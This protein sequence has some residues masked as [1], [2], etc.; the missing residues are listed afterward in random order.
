MN[1]TILVVDDSPSV[2]Q[3]LATH[4]EMN[5]YQVLEVE[6]GLSALELLN[7]H[8]PAVIILDWMM[9]G[10]EGPEVAVR[11][12][13]SQNNQA[14][15]IIMLT[16]R[17]SSKDQ[18]QGLRTGVDLYVTKPF[19]PEVLMVQVEKGVKEF[20]KRC[21]ALELARISQTDALTGLFN[22]RFFDEAIQ[23]EMERAD[24]YN[25][26]LSFIMVDLDHFKQVNDTYGHPVGD[27]VL[28]ELAQ[29][30]RQSVRKSDMVFRYGGEEF[31]I[32]LPEATLEGVTSLG[33]KVRQ[34]IENHQFA[35]VGH[36]TASL[37][38]TVLASGDTVETLIQRADAALYSAK[39]NGRN[40]VVCQ[41][42]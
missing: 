6:D 33:E 3:L 25:R 8:L 20:G 27:Q 1:N 35:G 12:R 28:R 19:D 39:R 13:E 15:Y 14:S 21:Q 5:E 34:A 42:T 11:I 2:R 16:A 10:M 41:V 7:S 9:P 23:L 31:A 29:V 40:Q 30:L 37:G 18:V 22:R 36:K 38:A 26:P 24:R 32:L 17:D 4:L